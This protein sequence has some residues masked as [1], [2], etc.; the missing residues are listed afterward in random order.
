MP[1]TPY[2]NPEFFANYFPQQTY[3]KP[4]DI[5][6]VI[7]RGLAQGAGAPMR[8]ALS[9]SNLYQ[10]IPHSTLSER[11]GKEPVKTDINAPIALAVLTEPFTFPKPS[12]TAEGGDHLHA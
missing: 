8:R 9:I 2:L 3:Q 7:R 1:F 12:F 6:Q 11:W 10:N 4:L 5:Y